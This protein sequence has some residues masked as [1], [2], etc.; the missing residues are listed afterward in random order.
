MICTHTRTLFFLEKEVIGKINSLRTYYSREIA[1]CNAKNANGNEGFESRWK[2]F[3]AMSFLRDIV[4]PRKTPNMVK[5]YLGKCLVLRMFLKILHKF[6]S[7]VCLKF[8]H[9][10]NWKKNSTVILFLSVLWCF[11]HKLFH[12]EK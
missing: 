6:S 4:R 12:I 8:S 2:H 7:Q 10:E 9:K 3:H 1:K 11:L 5:I